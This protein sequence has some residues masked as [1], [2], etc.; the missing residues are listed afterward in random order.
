[1]DESQFDKTI[2]GKL[3]GLDTD[4]DYSALENFRSRMSEEPIHQIKQ[5]WLPKLVWP[6]LLILLITN[7][8][9][10]W[11]WMETNKNVALLQASIFEERQNR[12]KGFVADTVYLEGSRDTIYIYERT[13]ATNA[14][15]SIA[16]QPNNNVLIRGLSDKYAD[17]PVT[18]DSKIGQRFTSHK[19]N[20]VVQEGPSKNRSSSGYSGESDANTLQATNNDNYIL[21]A[22]DADQRQ[23]PGEATKNETA[24]D[25]VAINEEANPV[26]DSLLTM[27]KESTVLNISDSMLVQPTTKELRRQEREQ[28]KEIREPIP[29]GILLGLEGNMFAPLPVDG[30]GRQSPGVGLKAEFIVSRHL[31]LGTGLDIMRT[32]YDITSRD[33]IDIVET[34]EYNYPGINPSLGFLEQI[35]IR[36]NSMELP[37]QMKYYTALAQEDRVFIGGGWSPS[38]Y[39]Y[40]NFLYEYNRNGVEII[41]EKEERSIQFNTGMAQF[42]IGYER[43]ISTRFRLKFEAYFNRAFA[44][45]GRERMVIDNLGFRTSFW[46]DL[47]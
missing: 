44:P 35:E 34:G 43:Q 23:M 13:A 32:R 1:M 7:G 24:L 18:A 46:F 19:N 17:K 25:H 8:L 16:Q 27:D 31:R 41:T 28:Q 22:T 10:F 33:I 36:S 6:L 42:M 5:A 21:P 11:S 2:K 45:V 3:S 38:I 40:Q 12:N 20:S 9:S 29:F 14:T 26:S 39:F 47:K 30:T 15:T 4:F 37:L